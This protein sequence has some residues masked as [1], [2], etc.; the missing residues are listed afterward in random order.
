MSLTST[1][2]NI[3]R[4][5]WSPL[6]L[7]DRMEPSTP[8]GLPLLILVALLGLSGYVVV[9]SGLVERDIDATTER[10]LARIEKEEK[11]DLSDDELRERMKDA[12]AA[13][14]FWKVVRSAGQVLAAPAETLGRIFIGAG[15]IYVLVALSG[16]EPVYHGLVSLFVY[17]AYT[18]VPRQ[19]LLVL[20][21]VGGE[22]MTVETSLAV[23]L[24]S[25]N[26]APGAIYALLQSVDPFLIWFVTLAG[27]GV[28]RT[29][30][31]RAGK[32]VAACAG[33]WTCGAL[34]H[35]VSQYLVGLVGG[36]PAT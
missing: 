31:L 21:M 28:V 13:A 2:R 29:G 32:T 5:Y 15:V 12:R 26:E 36:G 7:F 33:L 8:Y 1:L 16:R 10:A 20:L 34:G 24:R 14:D 35:L 23:V 9:A 3:G 18:E 4:V 11:G 19:A 27:L 17:A 30:Q 22:T 6:R 25:R